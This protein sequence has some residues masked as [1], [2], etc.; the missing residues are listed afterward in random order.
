MILYGAVVKSVR[1]DMS[2]AEVSVT[3]SLD[4]AQILINRAKLADWQ[5]LKSHLTVEIRPPGGEQLPLLAEAPDHAERSDYELMVQGLHPDTLLPLW[6]VEPSPADVRLAA[7][8]ERLR[9]RSDAPRSWHPRLRHHQRCLC[10]R[11]GPRHVRRC[12]VCGCTYWRACPGGCYWVSAH[13]C[14]ACAEEMAD[15]GNSHGAS[16][17]SRRCAVEPVDGGDPYDQDLDTPED[18]EENWE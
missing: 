6:P 14:S 9:L 7:E 17:C 4:L 16:L 15:H 8:Y 2:A 13:L 5:E 1:A 12:R 10:R 18:D 3:L 11:L